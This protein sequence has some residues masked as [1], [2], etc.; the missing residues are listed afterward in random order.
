MKLV[1]FVLSLSACLS[2]FAQSDKDF[3]KNQYKLD[4]NHSGMGITFYR[5]ALGPI[6]K[7]PN[8][9][10]DVNILADIFEMRFGIGKVDA[11]GSVPSGFSFT[12]SVN[13]HYFGSNVYFGVNV[14]LNFLSFGAQNSA[15]KVFR[16]HPVAAGGLGWFEMIN[17][18]TWRDKKD[19]EVI[20]F[21][22][23]PGYRIRFPFGSIEGT[24]NMRLGIKAGEEDNRF[25]GF[26]VYPAITVRLDAMKWLY[27]THLVN[28]PATQ[29]SIS[30]IHTTEQRIGTRYEGYNQIDVYERTTTA[31]VSVSSITIGVQDIGPHIGIGPKVSFMNPKRSPYIPT[32]KMIGIVAEG[33]GGPISV[34]LTVEG[35]RI[36]MG[37][38]L[39]EK[40]SDK[41]TFRRKLDRSDT[42]GLGEISTVNLY[43]QIG[44]DISPVFLVPFGIG[45]DK[46]SATSFL[47]VV[48]GFNFGAH[49]SFNPQYLHPAAAETKYDAIVQNDQGKTKEK[50]LDPKAAKSGYLGGF[51]IA[52]EVGACSFKITNYRY[53]GAPFAS[54]TMMSVAYRFPVRK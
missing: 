3:R 41:H 17:S 21:G 11:R 19:A 24:L 37:G 38:T 28:V 54:T 13:D 8:P 9:W 32:S 51:F 26:G 30:N 2:L 5:P 6:A 42:I 40:D 31:D 35:G 14:P 49:L 22:L 23:A 16:G 27:N 46:G 18:S 33:R 39:E 44:F 7:T 43:T 25:K 29:T 36:G 1:F 12:E 52:V 47:S 20:Y 50:Y 34:G 45:M 48:A 53:Y 10:V 4:L 15:L